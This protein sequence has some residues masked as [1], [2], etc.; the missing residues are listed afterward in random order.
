MM[1]SLLVDQTAF[2]AQMEIK[3]IYHSDKRQQ[4]KCQIN[5]PRVGAILFANSTTFALHN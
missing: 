2:E 3:G 5:R 4:Q 1:K